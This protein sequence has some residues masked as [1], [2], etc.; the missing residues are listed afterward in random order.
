MNWSRLL[1]TLGLVFLAELGDKTQLAVMVQTC[2]YQTRFPVFVGGSAALML[3][4]AL[5]TL[6]GQLAGELIPQQ[7]IRTLAGLGFLIMGVFFWREA[8]ASG[9]PPDEFS[10][11]TCTEAQFRRDKSWNWEAFSA[12]LGLV[13]LAEL[14][15]KTQLAIIGLASKTAASG[16][17]FIGSVL[18]LTLVTALGVIGGRELCRLIP[19]RLMLRLSAGLFVVMGGLIGLGMI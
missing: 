4:S 15:D 18:A 13:F 6:G 8:S 1:S 9:D 5:G 12:T 11:G 19:Q 2:K 3:V 16:S 17:I 7:V 14:G 10:T